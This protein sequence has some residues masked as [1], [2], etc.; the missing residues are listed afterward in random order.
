[1]HSLS[2][3]Y[4][5]RAVLY[6]MLLSK[7]HLR[8]AIRD[9]ATAIGA[10]EP[11]TARILQTLVRAGVIQ[12]AKGPGGGFSIDSGQPVARID[13]VRIIDG[14]HSFSACGLGWKEYSETKP[15]PLPHTFRA[16]REKLYREC[17]RLTVRGLAGNLAKGKAYLK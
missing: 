5:L 10:N 15:C 13:I 11:T 1:M 12:S 16:A 3:Q 6:L 14:L 8:M 2:C 4:A 7:A 9:V 17:C